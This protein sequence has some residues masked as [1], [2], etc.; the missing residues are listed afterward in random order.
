M[1]SSSRGRVSRKAVVGFLASEVGEVPAVV[2]WQAAQEVKKRERKGDRGAG[3]GGW[4]CAWLPWTL[5]WGVAGVPEAPV[6]SLTSPLLAPEL[7]LCWPV[8]SHTDPGV[9][10]HVRDRMESGL[11]AIA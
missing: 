6:N 5:T 10:G 4:S 1:V 7:C 8:S 9:M 2:P 3:S 11:P